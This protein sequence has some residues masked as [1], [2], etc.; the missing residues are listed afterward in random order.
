[1]S[2]FKGRS[3]I[4]NKTENCKGVKLG[5]RSYVFYNEIQV[6][7]VPQKIEGFFNLIT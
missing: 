7:R 6:K 2:Y 5:N 3:G 1:M 4:C